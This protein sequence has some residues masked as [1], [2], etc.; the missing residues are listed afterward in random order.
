MRFGFAKFV[1]VWVIAAMWLLTVTPP[2]GAQYRID[3]YSTDNG[4]PQNGVRGIVQTNDGYLWFTTFDGLVRFDGIKFT[5]FDKNNSPGIASNRF[6]QLRLLPDGALIAGTEEGGITVYRDRVFRTYT[7]ADGLPTNSI[8][9]FVTDITGELVIVTTAGNC[10]F[11]NGK[12]PT[13]PA[14]SFPDQGRFYYSP[15][16]RLWTYGAD[17]V[18]ER[19]QDGREI[20]YPIKLT[21]YNDNFAGIHLFEDSRGFLWLGDADSVFQLKDGTVRRYTVKDGVPEKTILRPFLEDKSGAIWFST[22]YF[23]YTGKIGLVRFFDGRFSVWG[24]LAGLGNLDLGELFLDREGTIWAAGDGGLHHVRRQF[25]RSYSVA[26]GLPFPEVYPILQTRNGDIYVGTVQGLALYRD[27]KFSDL[28]VRFQGNAPSVTALHEDASGNIW[29]GDG[30][31]LFRLEVQSLRKIESL[32]HTAVWAITSSRDGDLIVGTGSGL[33]K[34]KG[35]LVVAHLSR[36]NGLPDDDVK[37]VWEDKGGALWVGTY[38]GLTVLSTGLN[39]GADNGRRQAELNTFTAGNGLASDRVRSLHQDPDGTMWIGTYDGGLSRLKDGKLFNYTIANGLFNNGVFQILDD[40]RGNFWISCNRGV[41]RVAKPELNDLAEG[42]SDRLTSVA[43]GKADGMLNTE[44]NGGRQPAGIRSADGKLWYPTQSGVIV[45]DPNDVTVNPD[46]PPVQIENV[47]VERQLVSAANG[48]SMRANSDNLEIRFTGISFVKPEQVKFRYRLEGLSDNWTDLGTIREVYF[49]SLPAGEYTFHVVAANSDGVWNTD[50][51][52]LKLSVVAP[53]WK[54]P[55]FIA[56]LVLAVGMIALL[57]FRARVKELK[58]RQQVQ[59][60]F[61]R[62]LLESQE[63]ERQRI[64]AELHDSIGQSL[65]IIKNR[66]FIALNDI[67]EPDTVKEQLEE[68]SESAASAIDEC[69]EISYNLRP[70]Q[71]DRFGLSKTL[72]A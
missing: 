39:N 46:P 7:T 53:F 43:Y 47:L 42:R 32:P 63:Q 10:Y 61:S 44:C 1:F 25:I 15:S 5:V 58:R 64:A 33:F 22:G 8:S 37:V 56:F 72:E 16:K 18:K 21:Y 14:E 62:K 23:G 17:G 13:V 26:D 29:V 69:R 38:G 34:L 40:N 48:I 65:L 70:Y 35:E 60:E 50:G 49:P 36:E 68:L 51:A 66:A 71:I 11:R 45:I 55:W 20:I 31:A 27:G 4:L 28:K 57:I 2:L 6:A 12:F 52:R 19:T 3:T 67:D 54:R 30:T 9:R 59:Q 24:Q 41:Y